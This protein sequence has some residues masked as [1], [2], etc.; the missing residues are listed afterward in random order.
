MPASLRVL[1]LGNEILGDDAFGIVV[2]RQAAAMLPPEDVE[3][4]ISS[5][6]GF[7][8]IDYV[9]GVP[10]LVVVDTIQSGMGVPGQIFSFRER[11]MA[12]VVGDTPHGIGIFDTLAL[13]RKLGLTTPSEVTV[14]AVEAADCLTVGGEMHPALEDAIPRGLEMIRKMAAPSGQ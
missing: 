3:V 6:S 2:A 7:N 14:I 9:L 5:E 8:L 12:G 4:E 11:D 1:G 13:A 10:R